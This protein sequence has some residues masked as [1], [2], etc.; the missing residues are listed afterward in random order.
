M[1][2]FWKGTITSATLRRPLECSSVQKRDV[3]RNN[4]STATNG[5]CRKPARLGV[6][7]R[8]DA[9]LSP[10]QRCRE[11]GGTAPARAR[12]WA[13]TAARVL[14]ARVF[15]NKLRAELY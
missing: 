14:N 12:F 10:R 6:L 15:Q 7:G 5:R 4:H 3:S 11:S 1:F 2:C 8:G 9:V 13:R